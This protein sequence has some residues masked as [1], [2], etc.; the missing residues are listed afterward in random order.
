[1]SE[2]TSTSSNG[3]QI[4]TY[5]PH[6]TALRRNGQGRSRTFWQRTGP[7]CVLSCTRWS[8]LFLCTASEVG[9]I[10]RR[11]YITRSYIYMSRFGQSPLSH[12]GPF[13][14]HI[15]FAGALCCGRVTHMLFVGCF[16]Q[17]LL[18]WVHI[19]ISQPARSFFLTGPGACC[20]PCLQIAAG[21]LCGTVFAVV[22]RITAAPRLAHYVNMFFS[23][24]G[25]RGTLVFV[26]VCIAVG[27][28]VMGP[29]EKWWK[30]SF[31]EQ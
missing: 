24:V 23:H 8:S 12:G 4:H 5:M 27:I 9:T 14:V 21:A 7:H 29:L 1:M 16:T 10:R 20:A 2:R 15:D 17:L 25:D 26:L 18:F 31:A 11:R 3:T 6:S 13:V 30:K 19:C 28:F 22:W